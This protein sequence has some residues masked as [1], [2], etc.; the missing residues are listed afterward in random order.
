M[1]WK[2]AGAYV[3]CSSTTCP[4]HWKTKRKTTSWCPFLSPS[5]WHNSLQAVSTEDAASYLKWE[6][7]AWETLHP[8]LLQCDW[9]IYY[10]PE[11]S[12][13]KKTFEVVAAVGTLCTT[14]LNLYRRLFYYLNDIEEHAAFLFCFLFSYFCDF[15]HQSWWQEKRLLGDDLLTWLFSTQC[16][17]HSRSVPFVTCHGQSKMAWRNWDV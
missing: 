7:R 4:S 1:F 15:F 12:F 6:Q 13:E 5:N 17:T 9:V 3:I 16:T 10:L 14:L 11:W 2:L 8:F